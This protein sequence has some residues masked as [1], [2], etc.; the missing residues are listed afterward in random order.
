[1]RARI[2]SLLLGLA[3]AAMPMSSVF[4][5]TGGGGSADLGLEAITIN[6]GNV[7]PKTGFVTLNGTITCNQDLTASVGVEAT[8]VVGRFNTIRGFGWQEVTC[9][10]TIATP[11]T[12]RF[13]LSFFA[14]Q[15]KFAPGNVRIS[16][17]ADTFVCGEF[18]CVGD[19]ATFGPATLR[20]FGR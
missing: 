1:M 20:L 18:E 5:D 2:V 11:G 16:A 14:D 15:G 6:G 7:A 4:A 9:S 13:S 12:A 10:G 8:Q 19:F 17:Y 3:L